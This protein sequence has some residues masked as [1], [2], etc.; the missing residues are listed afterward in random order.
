MVL[1]RLSSALSKGGVTAVLVGPFGKA[2]LGKSGLFFSGW[3]NVE[4]ME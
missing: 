4:L 1:R 2:R 3:Q